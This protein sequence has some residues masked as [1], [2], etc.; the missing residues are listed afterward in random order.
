MVLVNE[1]RAAL[2]L[3]FKIENKL[4]K[5]KQLGPAVGGGLSER[6]RN[7]AMLIAR[8]D[9]IAGNRRIEDFD[10]VLVDL[11]HNGEPIRVQLRDRDDAL[12][13]LGGPDLFNLNAPG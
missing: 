2:D 13:L 8:N 3:E 4:S 6:E 9:I 7:L 10:N 5:D 12:G 11:Q 1:Q